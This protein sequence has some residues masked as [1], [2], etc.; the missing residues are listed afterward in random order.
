VSTAISVATTATNRYVPRGRNE[1]RTIFE[2]HFA[3]FCEHFV[4][5][6]AATYGVYRLDADSSM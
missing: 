1:L 3:N 2:H 4:E 6:Y 5:K